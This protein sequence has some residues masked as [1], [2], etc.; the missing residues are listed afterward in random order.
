MEA[1]PSD[2]KGFGKNVVP[3]GNYDNDTVLIVDDDP[4][5]VNLF[6]RVLKRYGYAT[7]H[8]K[9]VEEILNLAESGKISFISMDIILGLRFQGKAVDGIEITKML[10]SNPKTALIPVVLVTS[11]ERQGDR[12]Y[13]LMESG[14]DGYISKPFSL[15]N[16][17]DEDEVR[18]FINLAKEININ[19]PETLINYFLNR[20]KFLLINSISYYTGIN[21]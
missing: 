7:L 13:F 9:D 4:A 8:T 11:L 1:E 14:A 5:I 19:C 12:E 18:K 21:N 17:I 3:A 2:A 16:W 15:E 10:K 20:Q 6:S